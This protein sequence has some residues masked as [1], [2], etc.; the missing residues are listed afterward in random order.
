MSNIPTVLQD[1]LSPARRVRGIHDKLAMPL[2]LLEPVV[3]GVDLVL[4]ITASVLA[5]VGYH[6]LFL[7]RVPRVEPY[8]AIAVIAYLNFATVM[9]A[10]GAYRFRKLLSFKLQLSY[11]TAVWSGVFLLLLAIAFSLKIG[12]TFSRGAAFVFLVVGLLLIITWRKILAQLLTG[13]LASGMF[14]KRKTIIIGERELLATSRVLS[15]LRRYGYAPAAILQISKTDCANPFASPALAKTLELAVGAAREHDIDD[16]LLFVR[17]H[18]SAC[19]E[20]LVHALSVLPIPVRLVPDEKVVSYLKR[21]YSIG[22]MWTA[23]LKR[24]PLDIC[25]LGLK[26]AIDLLGAIA[27]LILL[28]PLMLMTAA[29]I[30]LESKGP[31]LFI[32]CRRGFNGR[33]FRIVKFRTMSVLEDGPI[34][35][36]ATRSDPRFTRVGRWLRRTNIDELPQL[37]NVLRG[38]MSLVGPRPHAVAHDDEYERRIAT[39]AFRYHVKPG[40][41]GWAQL[42]GFRGETRTLDLMSKRIECDLWYIK[43]WSL[44]LDLRILFG[45]LTFGLWRSSG[46]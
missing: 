25:E 11:A 17:W 42:N 34:I 26:R 32:Q 13:A 2:A 37:F 31:V 14:A 41:T 23:E 33:I 5:G 40:M 3:A 12:D 27:G 10:S 44:L 19:I 28:S 6:W 16:V 22:D 35:R 4:L 9:L 8:V 36:Q 29:L 21:T 39:Y 7:D 46:Y 45:T 1:Q 18:H 15:E 20:R 30:K 38:E 24:A 43:H